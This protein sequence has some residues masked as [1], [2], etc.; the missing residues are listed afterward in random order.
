VLKLFPLSASQSLDTNPA[1]TQAISVQYFQ[2]AHKTPN[3][4]SAAATA[5]PVD[6]SSPVQADCQ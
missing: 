4:S 3:P 2:N 6:F 1:A 5:C